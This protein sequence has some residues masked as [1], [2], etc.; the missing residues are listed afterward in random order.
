MIAKLTIKKQYSLGRNERLK[1]HKLIT[2]LFKQG[3]RF[4]SFPIRVLYILSSNQE[5]SLQAGFSASSKNF[6][7]AVDRNRIKR[8]LRECY[9]LQK[10]ALQEH[11][12]NKTQQ[13]SIF[14]IYTASELPEYNILSE[15]MKAALDNLIVRTKDI[16]GKDQ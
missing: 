2:K 12:K 15:K 9:R 7:K 10:K 5:Q 13:L 11:L 1:S 14:F 6:K 3:Q 16:P 8:L 4:S